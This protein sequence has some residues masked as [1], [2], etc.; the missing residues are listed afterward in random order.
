MIISREIALFGHKAFLLRPPGPDDTAV[1]SIAVLLTCP[2]HHHSPADMEMEE[3]HDFM[4]KQT[5]RIL[6][7][8]GEEGFLTSDQISRGIPVHMKFIS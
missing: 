3:V 4:S 7:Y 6:Y 2:K 5:A 1:T 8:L